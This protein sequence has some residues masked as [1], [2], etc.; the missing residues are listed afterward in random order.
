MAFIGKPVELIGIAEVCTITKLSRPTIYRRLKSTTFPKPRKSLATAARGPRS[1]NKWS[2]H[3]VVA[4]VDAAND[5]TEE[6][7][8]QISDTAAALMGLGAFL[9]LASLVYYVSV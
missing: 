1:V 7:E 8:R 9:F 5:P 6:K 2:K 4:W 3:E